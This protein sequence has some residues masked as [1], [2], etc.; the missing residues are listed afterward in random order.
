MWRTPGDDQPTD[1]IRPRHDRPPTTRPTIRMP[2]EDLG[3]ALPEL[4]VDLGETRPPL[5]GLSSAGSR[6]SSPTGQKRI[7]S[8]AEPLVYRL[9]VSSERGATWID[10]DQ[11]VWLCAVRRQG[12]R[13]RRRC[14]RPGSHSSHAIRLPTATGRR[15]PPRPGRRGSPRPSPTDLGP[16]R[17]GRPGA[18]Q[19]AGPS[20]PRILMAGCRQG[21]LVIRAAGVGGDLVRIASGPRTEPSSERRCATCCSSRSK[22]TSLRQSSRLATTGPPAIAPGTSRS[23]SGSASRAVQLRPETRWTSSNDLPSRWAARAASPQASTDRA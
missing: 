10:D 8:I 23:G 7:L 21:Q 16:V 6:L 5:A 17:S 11:V 22:T 13:V 14:L 2:V 3:L 20:A 9:R 15:P 18:C 19:L 1:T 12:G 4:A